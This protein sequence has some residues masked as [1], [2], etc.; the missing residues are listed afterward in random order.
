MVALG[1]YHS[2]ILLANG[3]LHMSGSNIFGQFGIGDDALMDRIPLQQFHE[4][5]GSLEL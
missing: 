2:A 3:Q 4:R 1:G 5:L